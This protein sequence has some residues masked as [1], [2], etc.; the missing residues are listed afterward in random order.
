MHLD[1]LSH[2]NAIG[3]TDDR[4]RAGGE[5]NAWGNSFPAEEL[6][7]GGEQRVD[8]VSFVL[9]ARRPSAPDHVE[10]LSQV[11][12]VLAPR[13]ASFVALLCCGEMGDQELPIEAID[14]AGRATRSVLKV[15]G[16]LVNGAVVR[17][18][19][20]H[21]CTH[22]HYPGDYDLAL[23]KPALWC[24]RA[25]VQTCGPMAELRLGDNPLVHVFAVTLLDGEA[26]DG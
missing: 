9:P 4:E 10:A 13:S 22:L 5:L 25:S 2:R 1:L 18:Q 6:W 16:W 11:I 17:V 20:G 3:A 19:S 23:L 12:R 15:P 24:V 21:L 8:D 26:I 14:T 7:F